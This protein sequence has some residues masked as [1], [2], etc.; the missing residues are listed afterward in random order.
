VDPKD[1]REIVDRYRSAMAL[2]AERKWAEAIDLLQQVLRDEPAAAMVWSDLGHVATLAERHSMALDAYQRVIA[3]R[4]L[5]DRGYLGAAGAALRDHKLDEAQQ[6]AEEAV[7]ASGTD[8][9]RMVASHADAARSEAAMVKQS[10]PATVWPVYV[11]ARLLYD[12]GYYAEALPL[13]LRAI[14]ELRT[15]RAEPMPDLHYATGDVLLQAGQYQDAEAQLREELRR[16]PH[17]VRASAALVSLYQS[18]GQLES[19]ARV[20]SEL[21]RVTP[22]PD[23]YTLAARLWTSVGDLKQAAQ[24]TD[25]ARRLFAPA[26]GSRAPRTS[27]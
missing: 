10:D 6:L 22:T 18:T 19:A 7:D 3:L 27:H 20:V 11:D 5:D 21:T 8:A 12:E 2:T 24:I 4:P 25:E 26:K 14:T 15:S 23:S 17:N 1:K 16:F 9:R 13:F